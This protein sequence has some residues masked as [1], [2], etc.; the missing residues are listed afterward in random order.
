MQLVGCLN[1]FFFFKHAINN[2]DFTVLLIEAGP[3]LLAPVGN[4]VP[5]SQWTT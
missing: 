4:E 1:V 3:C 5:G 2:L